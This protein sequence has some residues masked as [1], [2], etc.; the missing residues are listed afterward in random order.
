MTV[1]VARFGKDHW[2]A[3]AYVECCAVDNKGMLDNR[4]MRCDADRHPGLINP[5]LD[6]VQVHNKYP[7]FL[8]GGE[9]L[10][11]H[12]DWD[13]LDDLEAAGFIEQ[14]GTGIHPVIVMTDLGREV[15]TAIRKHKATQD[16]NFSNFRWKPKVSVGDVLFRDIAPL[17]PGPPRGRRIDVIGDAR[18]TLLR[19]FYQGHLLGDLEAFAL[20]RGTI[21][22]TDVDWGS[23]GES[24]TGR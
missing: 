18:V 13:C 1:E 24:V 12:D 2:S 6:S 7:T 19:A 11:D 3:L 16:G 4:R 21:D 14:R 8:A 10:P 5:M 22:R 15:V 9:E 17:V 20:G 23:V